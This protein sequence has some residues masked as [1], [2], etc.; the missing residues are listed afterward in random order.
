MI[1]S[2]IKEVH[3]GWYIDLPQWIE[4]GG[5]KGALAMVAGADT[6]LDILLNGDPSNK[7]TLQLEITNPHDDTFTVLYLIPPKK[8]WGKLKQATF[9]G[10]DYILP[11]YNDKMVMHKMW[12]CNVTK[13]VFG[14][15]PK[16]IYFK[17]I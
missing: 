5:G 6:F 2:F 16:V 9:G 14:Y 8:L 1:H 17:Q 15:F 11:I 12:L 4:N 7:V 13:F 3:G 10:A